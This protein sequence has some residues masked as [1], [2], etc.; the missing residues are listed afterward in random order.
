MSYR[1]P[2]GFGR[3]VKLSVSAVIDTALTVVTGRKSMTTSIISG[4]RL[5]Q[6]EVVR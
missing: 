5:A 4:Y 2:P 6:V 1:D 3:H